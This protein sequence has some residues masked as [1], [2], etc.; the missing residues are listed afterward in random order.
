M[1]IP[2]LIKNLLISVIVFSLSIG[3]YSQEK[4]NQIKGKNPASG[5]IPGNDAMMWLTKA[6]STVLF[7]K[8]DKLLRFSAAT[9]AATA[10]NVDENITFQTMEGAGCALT[11]GS[12]FLINRLPPK[13]RDNLL[14]ELFSDDSTFIG[15]SYIRISIGSSDLNQAVFTYDDIDPQPADPDL[16]HFSIAPDMKDLIPV[17]KA[18]I[19]I[20][21]SIRILA[22]PWSAPSWMKTNR[23]SKGGSLRPECYSVY[24]EYFVKYLKAM[25]ESGITID[26]VTVQN[27]PE[28]PGN[29]PS[30]VMTATEQAGFIKSYLGPAFT[31]ANLRTKILVFDHNCDHPDYPLTILR[32]PDAAKYIEGSAFHLYLGDISALAKVH[33]AFPAKGIYFTEQ[34]VGGSAKNNF[35]GDL[36]WHVK[37]LTVG[38]PLNWSR[39]VVWWNLA[40]DPHYQPHTPGG[41]DRCLGAV[42]IGSDIRRNVAYYF[43][44][45]I[46]KFVRPGSVRIGSTAI[47]N[48]PNAAFKTPDGKKV[49]I[50]LNDSNAMQYFSIRDGNSYLDTYLDAGSVA[51]YVW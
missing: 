39:N 50:V 42:T 8:Q 10:I 30:M 14:M 31:K 22:S 17:L 28:N 32:D 18:I 48:L 19:K 45:H 46:S 15:I 29:N 44:A 6:D 4:N 49:L 2:G 5:G 20:N 1:K 36:Q 3:G 25:K 21:P 38:A 47:I 40:S 11:G 23:S 51:T 12:A 7:R 35:A 9:T 16:D 43:M 27:E 13:E 41:C 33:D 26:A 34:W 37:N 24:A